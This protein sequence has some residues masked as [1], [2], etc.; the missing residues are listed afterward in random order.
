MTI[1][2]D[3]S[4]DSSTVDEILDAM[5]ADA[6]QDWSD[7]INEADLATIR[8]FYR[9]IAERLSEAQ[10]DIGLVL[11]STQI[12]NAEGFAL[13]LLT[14]L[15]GVTRLPPEKA[16]GEVTFSR[17]TV[18]DVDYDIPKGTEVQTEEEPP[19]KFVTTEK[20]VI[21]DGG[22]SAT[23][24][25]IANE[26]GSDSN[27]KS[28]KITVLP[29]P[30][31]GIDSVNN[32]EATT[33]GE[34]KE[35]DNQLRNRAKGELAEGSS[36]TAPALVSG[37]KSVGG[38]TSVSVLVNDTKDFD[39]RGHGLPENSAEL[40]VTGGA[41]DDVAQKLIDT[42]GMDNTLVGGVN[43]VG[44]DGLYGDLPN[45]QQLPVSFS[46][47]NPITIYINAD[48]Q[49]QDSYEGDNAVLDNIVDYIGGQNADGFDRDG[50]LGVS[51]TVVY[52]EIEYRIREINGVYDVSNL[53]IGTTDP[54]SGMSNIT[55]G[56]MEEATADANSS[57]TLTTSGM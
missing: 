14:A 39:G 4:F 56:A 8:Q 37:V 36:A 42:K 16:T 10:S 15:V 48:I 43:G 49:T 23:A 2:D 35:N 7:D 6:K 25:I 53:E 5:I 24:P 1:S 47:A 11:K 50:E 40:I 28:G 27:L 57:I 46:R 18:A 9:P 17:N 44:V 51:D 34:N 45:G 13:N 33:G 20:A 52:G 38:V 26:A 22:Y 21:K 41:D 12:D 32:P 55:T 54:P 31:A 19:T 3:G 30:L 29:V